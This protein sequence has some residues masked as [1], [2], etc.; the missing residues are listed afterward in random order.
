MVAP[1]LS[2]DIPGVV[3]KLIRESLRCPTCYTTGAASDN[4]P[5]GPEAGFAEMRRVGQVLAT[6]AAKRAYDAHKG[7]GPLRVHCLTRSI[8]L[9]L[10]TSEEFQ[11]IL[12]NGASEGAITG[13]LCRVE[14]RKTNG[15]CGLLS[16]EYPPCLRPCAAMPPMYRPF[17]AR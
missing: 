7:E 2:A 12:L 3:R 16:V 11:Q 5:K 17:L 15:L 4:H 14:K 9:R 8:P 6:E 13:N 10:R 1:L